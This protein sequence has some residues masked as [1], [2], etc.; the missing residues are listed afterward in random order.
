[1]GQ[2]CRWQ[3]SGHPEVCS[4]P[5]RSPWLQL[6]RRIVVRIICV[7]LLDIW[8]TQGD[9]IGEDPL[10]SVWLCVDWAGVVVGVV[11]VEMLVSAIILLSWVNILQNISHCSYYIQYIADCKI[12][13]IFTAG[14]SNSSY[15]IH[16]LKCENDGVQKITA[17][18]NR[19]NFFQIMDD[20]NSSIS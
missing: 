5:W 6:V 17:V 14:L 1:M 8:F 4:C 20:Y 15:F 3:S 11:W 13:H 7:P 12:P 2:R 18:Q 9:V 16:F 19:T 10:V